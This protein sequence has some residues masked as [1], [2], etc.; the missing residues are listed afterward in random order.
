MG[1]GGGEGRREGGGDRQRGR[2]GGRDDGER[3]RNRTRGRYLLAATRTQDVGT[4]VE[5]EVC[6]LD[7]NM[8]TVISRHPRLPFAAIL[9]E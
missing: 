6:Y 9:G 1:G 5:G 8:G 7:G 4:I 3:K 2:E